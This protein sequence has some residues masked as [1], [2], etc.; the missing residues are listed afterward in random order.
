MLLLLLLLPFDAN[1]TSRFSDDEEDVVLVSLVDGATVM[2]DLDC[3][4]NDSVLER[5]W[6]GNASEVSMVCTH[7]KH[8]RKK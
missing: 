2:E 7:N 3:I 6:T 8:S 5:L 4:L 1:R